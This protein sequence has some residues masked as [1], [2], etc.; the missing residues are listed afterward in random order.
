NTPVGTVSGTITNA[1]GSA[2]TGIT[3]TLDDGDAATTD[4]TAVTDGS[5]NYSFTN[6]PTGDYT[7]VQTLP[8]NTTVVDGDTSDDGDTVANTDT[9]DGSI[10]V[11]VTA[12]ETDTDNN[13]ENTPVGTVSGTITN[14]DGS[15]A[16]GITVTLDDGDAATTDPTAVTDG[17]GNYSF[18]NVPTGDYTIVQTLPAN[19]TVVDGDTSD[20]G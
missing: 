9:T 16:T 6:V 14:A 18:T 3:V 12:G 8:A 13:F 2:A 4:P 1:D 15:A 17:S 10:P 11:T 7:I 20:D 5:G 19:T